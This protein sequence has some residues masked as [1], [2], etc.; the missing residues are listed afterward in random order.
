MSVESLALINSKGQVVDDYVRLL[1]PFRS[2]GFRTIEVIAG[3]AQKAGGALADSE[4][5]FDQRRTQPKSGAETQIVVIGS[6][7][8][9]QTFFIGISGV[10]KST[11]SKEMQGNWTKTQWSPLGR[12]VLSEMPGSRGVIGKNLVID[13]ST[14]EDRISAPALELGPASF[15]YQDEE[16]LYPAVYG[17]GEGERE[18]TIVVQPLPR[19]AEAKFPKPKQLKLPQSIGARRLKIVAASSLG[20]LLCPNGTSSPP[21]LMRPDGRI[22]QVFNN[23]QSD[24]NFVDFRDQGRSAIFWKSDRQHRQQSELVLLDLKLGTVT[25]FGAVER[26]SK[27][28]VVLEEIRKSLPAPPFRWA[29]FLV[30]YDSHAVVA[31]LGESPAMDSMPPPPPAIGSFVFSSSGQRLFGLPL[32]SGFF[33][34]TFRMYVHVPLSGSI[35]GHLV[36]KIAVGDLNSASVTWLDRPNT[37]AFVYRPPL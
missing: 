24:I 37:F 2:Y 12:F 18:Y 11:F 25:P 21:F 31:S 29:W 16:L 3:D 36:D 4:D 5:P 33:D 7:L 22:L 13:G 1:E 19:R 8:S 32:G 14:G 34:R 17:T 26:S 6:E 30:S 20:V 10:G 27:Q 28:R 23:E 35:S 15:S 9:Q